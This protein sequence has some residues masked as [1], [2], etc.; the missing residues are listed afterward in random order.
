MRK[1]LP[2]CESASGNEDMHCGWKGKRNVEKICVA[3]LDD[4]RVKLRKGKQFIILAL[5]FVKW[6]KMHENRKVLHG[7][8]KR[9][10]GIESRKRVMM[11]KNEQSSNNIAEISIRLRGT[12]TSFYTSVL[13][14]ISFFSMVHKHRKKRRKT[15]E[16]KQDL[17]D[18][19]DCTDEWKCI[20]CIWRWK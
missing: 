5:N 2:V 17:L 10:R 15:S 4:Q 19:R 9:V 18:R 12:S 1:F 14:R 7:L 16:R 11:M 6:N 20:Y 3:P 8:H 13:S